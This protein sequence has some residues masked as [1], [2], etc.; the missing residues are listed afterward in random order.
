MCSVFR[1]ASL[2]LVV[3]CLALA[4]APEEAANDGPF[5]VIC[6][7]VTEQGTMIDDGIL[8]LVNRAIAE[9]EG[10]EAI[11]FIID[12]PG[13]RLDSAIEI[14]NSIMD[15][16]CKTIAYIKG[17]G[18]ISAGAL[19]SYSCD[20]ITMGP[21]SNI[22]AS[23][24]VYFTGEG[25]T[26]AGEKETSFLRSKF[27]ALGE[28]KGHNPDIGM[29]MVDKDIELIAVPREEGGYDVYATNA[30]QSSGSSA[31]GAVNEIL[32]G[33]EENSEIDLG[34]LKEL[35]ESIAGGDEEGPTSG[36]QAVQAAI[37][38]GLAGTHI[39]VGPDKLLTLTPDEAVKYNLATGEFRTLENLLRSE[40]LENAR[41]VE[42]EL[43][44][45]EELFRWLTSPTVSGILLMLG[46]GGLYL[47]IRTPGFGLP[48]IIG[49]VA[50]ALYFGARS[51]IGLA[52]WVDLLLVLTGLVLIAIEAF[53]LPGFGIAGVA[54]ILCLLAGLYLSFTF[55]DFYLP[56]YS[57]SVDRLQ[58][59]GKTVTLTT[60]GLIVFT[61]ILWKVF[62]R[63]PIY[64]RLVLADAQDVAMGYSV[65]SEQD[66]SSAIGLKGVATSMLRPAG[67]GR[68]GDKTYQVVSR[69]EFI[70]EGTPITIVEVEGNRY[71]VDRV[72]ENA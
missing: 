25:M 23:Q 31:S 48:G 40:G 12:T 60:V 34:P 7:I 13:G 37:Q 14:T 52:D 51:V 39:V 42:L 15:A 28:E 33:I 71:V 44:W 38:S 2:L 6:P 64:G 16:P 41:R 62:P 36:E 8:V 54:G 20:V 56:D 58:D 57:W 11:I 45:S 55:S 21:G 61:V 66:R 67:R 70:E 59:A 9:A 72:K 30:G 22:G 68:F 18:A 50:L 63:T 65:Q 32:E 10:A 46:I 27:A 69:A 17:T 47:E 26:P 43:T 53:V 29:A 24:V 1:V 49:I 19:I 5:V 4:Q 3:S 35:V